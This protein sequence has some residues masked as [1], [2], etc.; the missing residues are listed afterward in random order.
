MV[1]GALLYLFSP[2]ACVLVGPMGQ[3]GVLSF[4]LLS[5]FCCFQCFGLNFVSGCSLG[6]G[7]SNGLV[8]RLYTPLPMQMAFSSSKL[9]VWVTMV[10]LEYI[11]HLRPQFAAL[12]MP[13]SCIEQESSSIQMVVF[14]RPQATIRKSRTYGCIRYL[15]T[16]YYPEQ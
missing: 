16:W 2:R 10:K 4:L 1:G 6:F 13:L 15:L 3:L 11:A 12:H 7:A 9:W 8:H 14:L 5:S